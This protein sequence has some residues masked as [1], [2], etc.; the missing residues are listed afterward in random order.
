MPTALTASD[1]CRLFAF[2][3]FLDGME[4]MGN[5]SSNIGLGVEWSCESKGHR[6]S[7]DLVVN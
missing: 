4:V 6:D 7:G 5:G 1:L 3:E 2:V